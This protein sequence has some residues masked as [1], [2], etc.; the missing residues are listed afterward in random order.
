MSLYSDII[1]AHWRPSGFAHVR[2]EKTV[3]DYISYV[4]S[5]SV[6]QYGYPL[7]S[8]EIIAYANGTT[9]I[10]EYHWGK[11]LSGTIGGAGGVGGLIYLTISNDQPS[12]VQRSRG[13]RDPTD[14]GF[15]ETALPLLDSPTNIFIPCYDNNGNIMGYWDGQGNVVAEYKYDA[16]GNIIGYRDAQGNAV[17]SYTYDDIGNRI[18]STEQSPGGSQLVATAYTANSLNQYTSISTSDF[19]LQ[20]SRLNSTM[21]AT[22]RSYKLRPVVVTPVVHCREKYELPSI[23]NIVVKNEQDHVNDIVQSAQEYLRFDLEA[24]ALKQKGAFF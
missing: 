11:D 9:N 3:F 24:F 23:K 10:I 7:R 16:F 13:T 20:I 21:T 19:R 2:G 17:A 8:K 15:I 5:D 6:V 1:G 4:A 22:R 18:S 12:T 14:G